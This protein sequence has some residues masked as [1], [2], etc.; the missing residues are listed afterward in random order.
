MELDT[1]SF[2][3]QA[4]VLFCLWRL[5]MSH[6]GL[7]LFPRGPLSPGEPGGPC[8]NRQKEQSECW[9]CNHTATMWRISK[10][11]VCNVVLKM[12]QCLRWLYGYSVVPFKVMLCGGNC[13]LMPSSVNSG[14][15]TFTQTQ[16]TSADASKKLKI[17]TIGPGRPLIPVTCREI[18]KHTSYS[19]YLEFFFFTNIKSLF[20][21]V[22]FST[23]L[24]IG[25]SP[26]SPFWPWI[27][28]NHKTFQT[29]NTWWL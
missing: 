6:T 23:T 7:P 8:C 14:S 24:T 3:V 25:T 13:S 17:L 11:I 16:E 1:L 28:R 26:G 18:I 21:R 22:I 15:W 5:W 12:S 9:Y 27:N 29:D 4:E 10:S 20:K 19:L 2:N